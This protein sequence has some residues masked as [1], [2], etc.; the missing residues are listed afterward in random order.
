VAKQPNPDAKK[1]ADTWTSAFYTGSLE[2]DLNS[3]TAS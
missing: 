1:K 2:R 3:T